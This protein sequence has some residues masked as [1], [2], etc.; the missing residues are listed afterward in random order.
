MSVEVEPLVDESCEAD[1]VY[2][3]LCK[4]AV[5]SFLLAVLSPLAFTWWWMVGVPLIGAVLALV[6]RGRIRR[7]PDEL[8]GRGLAAVSLLLNGLVAASS[9]AF[10]AGTYLTE[11]PPGYVR[12][13]FADLQ[14]TKDAP[15]L[16]VPPAAVKLDGQRVFVKGYLYPDGQ[17]YNI[18]RFVLIP[19]MGTC[20]F[21]GQPKLTDMI[22]VTLQDP[23]RV[24]F[25]RRMRRLGGVLHVDTRLKPVSGLGGVY[26][27]LDADYV[28]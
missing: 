2:R 15:H 7:Y 4:T 22:E 8:T 27:Q 26:Y 25:A 10:H 1:L 12:I 6:A 23:L 17:Q 11:V 16:P 24:V 20:C 9:I 14:P 18:K 21:G 28:R 13:S 5:V 19:D 3:A